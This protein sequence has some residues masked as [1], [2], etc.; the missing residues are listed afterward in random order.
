MGEKLTRSE[1]RVLEVAEGPARWWDG[2]MGIALWNL[3]DRSL[4]IPTEGHLP[5][6]RGGE[7]R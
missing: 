4:L 2:A 7:P 3:L 1:R 5:M 6:R